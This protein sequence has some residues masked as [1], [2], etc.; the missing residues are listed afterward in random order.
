MKSLVHSWIKC[1]LQNG[2]VEP[3]RGRKYLVQQCAVCDSVLCA[4]L[5]VR[6]TVV[7]IKQETGAWR[8]AIAY[9]CT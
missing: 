8:Y 6:A 1:E 2:R 7:T 5:S 9:L 3:G 4:L